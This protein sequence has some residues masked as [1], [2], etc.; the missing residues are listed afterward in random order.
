M[1]TSPASGKETEN[2]SK[3]ETKTL[4]SKFQETLAA[5]FT[6]S[7]VKMKPQDNSEK[8]EPTSYTRTAKVAAPPSVPEEDF[9]MQGLR[10]IVGERLKS[11]REL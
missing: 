8:T 3:K 6:K 2:P 5:T 11:M 4:S 1:T 7:T 10:E 9:T